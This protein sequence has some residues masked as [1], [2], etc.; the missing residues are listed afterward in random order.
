MTFPQL[1]TNASDGVTGN[2]TGTVNEKAT[3]VDI[4]TYTGLLPGK[5]YTV[6]GILMN[7]ETGEP[8]KD[9]EGK[10]ITA[11][12]T[13]TAEKAD[14]S[15]ELVYELDSSLLAGQTV[16]VFEDLLYNGVEVGSHADIQDEDQSVHYPDLGTQAKNQATGTQEAAAN[17]SVTI[18][19]TVSYKNLIPGQEYTVKGILMDKST[20][21]ELLVGDKTVTAEKTFIPEKADGS[22]ELAFTFDG[23]TLTGKTVVV[24]ERLYVGEN[25]V[26]VH[27]DITDKGQTVEFPVPEIGTK[28]KD[29]DTGSQQGIAKKQ[30]YDHRHCKL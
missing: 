19:D 1:H 8:V 29:K 2:H 21:K 23:S 28:A 25:E 16:V 24:F 13:F 27:A 12:K 14:G 10:E 15:V 3:V 20:G 4:V 5:E 9:A 6:K 11:E 22:V 7:K 30:D 18:L 17:K 26:A